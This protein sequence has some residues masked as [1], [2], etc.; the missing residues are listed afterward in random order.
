MTF[1]PFTR[2]IQPVMVYGKD[3]ERMGKEMLPG[4]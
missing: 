1:F 3:L 4:E 2:D